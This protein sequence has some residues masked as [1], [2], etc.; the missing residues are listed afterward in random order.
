MVAA[1]NRAERDYPDMVH[2][3]NAILVNA[4]LAFVLGKIKGLN[5]A[6]KRVGEDSVLTR[7][8][9]CQ[10]RR[11]SFFMMYGFSVCQT[12]TSNLRNCANRRFAKAQ[13]FQNL[14]VTL[15]YYLVSIHCVQK[16]S[17]CTD[18]YGIPGYGEG[19]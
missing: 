9:L 10:L 14:Q 16:R 1:V 8:R 2:A 11:R 13:S 17:V 18:P 5:E 15:R 7:V 12:K 6:V 3:R 4:R 19:V